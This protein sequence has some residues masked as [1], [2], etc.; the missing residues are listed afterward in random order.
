MRP[1]YR[2]EASVGSSDPGLER[3]DVVA[4]GRHVPDELHVVILEQIIDMERGSDAE[5]SQLPVGCDPDIDDRNRNALISPG[6]NAERYKVVIDPFAVRNEARV[7]PDP[8]R[9]QVEQG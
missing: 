4:Y 9:G 1:R 3:E 7:D 2:G 5:S 6:N 8:H